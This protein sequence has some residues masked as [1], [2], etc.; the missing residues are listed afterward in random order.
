MTAALVEARAR[1]LLLIH[2]PPV[3]NAINYLRDQRFHAAA[4]SAKGIQSSARAALCV[5]RAN[6]VQHTTRFWSGAGLAAA[7]ATLSQG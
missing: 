1:E 4:Q 3:S 6:H 5:S 7:F 2:N